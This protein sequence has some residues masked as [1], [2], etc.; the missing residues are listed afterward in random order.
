MVGKS[1]IIPWNAASARGDEPF[2]AGN[3]TRTANVV[4]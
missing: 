4:I 1:R 3:S 2:A